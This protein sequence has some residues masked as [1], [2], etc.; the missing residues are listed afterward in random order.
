[1]KNGVKLIISL[2]LPQLAALGGLLFTKTG[3]GSWYQT[4]QKREWNAPGWLFGP[5]W[6]L[7]YILMVIAFYRI[8]KAPDSK[9]KAIAVWFWIARLILNFLWTFIFFGLEEIRSW[10][11]EI[12]CLWLLILG[13]I[14]T[15]LRISK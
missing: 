4:L 6:T 1:M 11:L 13:T 10:L 8:S 12:I 14:I 9:Q 7:L 3:E 2:L 15:F 5:V